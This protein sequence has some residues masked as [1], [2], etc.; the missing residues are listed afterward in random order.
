MFRIGFHIKAVPFHRCKFKNAPEKSEIRIP[1]IVKKKQRDNK[2]VVVDTAEVY[3]YSSESPNP[4]MDC[5]RT[6][7]VKKKQQET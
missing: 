5:M 4:R 1:G 2:H 7:F 6:S 3:L